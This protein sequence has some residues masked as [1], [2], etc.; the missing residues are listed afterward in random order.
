M[1]TSMDTPISPA[2][3]RR[4]RAPE[5]QI[6]LKFIRASRRY[7]DE[8]QKQHKKQDQL[9]ESMEY[10]RI[11]AE[12][13]LREND[14]IQAYSPEEAADLFRR[15]TDPHDPKLSTHPARGVS[16]LKHQSTRKPGGLIDYAYNDGGRARAGYKT[17]ANDCAVRAIAILTRKPYAH[18]YIR[19]AAAMRRAG[20]PNSADDCHKHPRPGLKPAITAPQVQ[21]IV[22]ASYGIRPTNLGRGRLPTYTEAWL[23]H[24]DCLVGTAT[25]VAAITDGTLHDTFDG[26]FCEQRPYIRTSREQRT[27]KSIWILDPTQAKPSFDPAAVIP[28]PQRR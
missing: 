14:I 20:Y 16:E 9:F 6:A 28:P 23:L 24:G 12:L 21:Y 3:F 13:L 5:N 11:G 26:R 18:I 15:I 25:H 19:M 1:T 8:R 10:L 22:T 27:A 17:P 7:A 4:Y 2:A